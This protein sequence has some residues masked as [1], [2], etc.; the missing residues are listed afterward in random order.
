MHDGVA[1]AD[2]WAV[3][4]AR[5]GYETCE[6]VSN[7]EP[8]QQTWAKEKSLVVEDDWLFAITLAQV[9][10]FRPEVLF[11]NEYALFSASFLQ[12]L[13]SECPTIRLVLGWCGAPYRDPSIF[14]EYDIVLSSVPEL[15][16]DFLAQGHR[17]FHINHAFD[18]RILERIEGVS[19]N[20]SDFTF[21]GSIATRNGFHVQRERLL[22]ELIEKTP[23]SIWA[24]VH[25]TTLRERS[26]VK[27]RQFAH[28]VVQTARKAGV[29]ESLINATPGRKV[30]G[31]KERPTLAPPIDA[32][33]ERTAKPPLFGLEMFAQLARSR[34]SLNTH[35]DISALY[36]S[37]MRLY[38]ATGVGSCLLTDW[39]KNIGELFEPDEEI[40]TYK[41]AAECIEKVNYLLAHEEE[42]SMI[43]KMGQK[44]TLR[45]HNFDNR[46]ARLHELLVRVLAKR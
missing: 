4:L 22:V 10:D 27:V 45:D 11:V 41:T 8:L 13:R 37:N 31:W 44:R 21:L 32:R 26:G 2:F 14:R 24:D 5:L 38:E 23:L 9:K 25:R 42:R 28:S 29:P 46:A 30:M 35:I 1:W 17:S 33:L 40:V 18:P 36:A 7:I 6:V 16:E 15:V 3:A 34:I 43:A 19:G 39:R 20:D 12:R